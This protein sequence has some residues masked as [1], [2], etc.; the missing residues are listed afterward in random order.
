MLRDVEIALIP[1]T[2]QLVCRS[3]G[4]GKSTL[5]RILAGL[6]ISASDRQ[7]DHRPPPLRRVA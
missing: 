3:N 5:L 4:Y 1:G 7:R 2:L 6:D